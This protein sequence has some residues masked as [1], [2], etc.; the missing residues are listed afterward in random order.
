MM[1]LRSIAMNKPDLV[2]FFDGQ[3]PLC[4]NEMRALKT[5]DHQARIL[6][7]DVHDTDTMSCYPS[8]DKQRALSILHGIDQQGQLLYG[9]DVTVLA[10]R[11]VN[12]HRW[13]FITRM[14]I[15]KGI[16]DRMYLLFAKHRM[17][18]SR[19]FGQTQ[20]QEGVCQKK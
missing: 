4:C 5:A 12:R 14:P 2:I 1:N 10:W 18:L 11:L 17:R 20:C 9:L 3:C 8:I 13:L 6:L 7:V 15:L 16:S 19:W